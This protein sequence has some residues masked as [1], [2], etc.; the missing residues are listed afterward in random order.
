VADV[1]ERFV[2]LRQLADFM[3]APDLASGD[4]A[5]LL[6]ECL[7]SA[8]DVVAE[9]VGP[10]DNDVVTYTVRP[11]GA[12]LVLPDTDL[13][14]LISV[15]DPS[16]AAVTVQYPNLAAG[17]IALERPVPGPYTVAV[18]TRAFTASVAPAVKIIASHLFEIH[19]PRAFARQ[20]RMTGGGVVELSPVADEATVRRGFAIPA[21]AADLLAP[22]RRPAGF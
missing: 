6:D 2:T 10:L 12:S 22:F 8:L 9:R 7:D 15:T 20:N 1:D 13:E 3:R 21:R 4:D 19:R 16:G 17:V 5:D 14:E 18:R 11:R